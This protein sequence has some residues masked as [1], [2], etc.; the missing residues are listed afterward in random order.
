M[1]VMPTHAIIV[2]EDVGRIYVDTADGVNAADENPST[3]RRRSDVLQWPKE[4]LS[5]DSPAG[6]RLAASAELRDLTNRIFMSA[7]QDAELVP[8]TDGRVGS[9]A[10][11]LRVQ[12]ALLPSAVEAHAARAGGMAPA[13]SA[14]QGASLALA[15]NWLT[16]CC[17]R[18]K[19]VGE[20]Q[21]EVR[22]VA[23]ACC[24]RFQLTR[25]D[26]P[27]FLEHTLLEHGVLWKKR[28]LGDVYQ[29]ISY[30]FGENGAAEV[31]RRERGEEGGEGVMHSAVKIAEGDALSPSGG[32]LEAVYAFLRFLEA[33]ESDRCVR[34]DPAARAAA[35][36]FSPK[37]DAARAVL[38]EALVDLWVKTAQQPQLGGKINAN[39]WL[40]NS[41]DEKLCRAMEGAKA[42]L[43]RWADGKGGGGGGG[44]G[45]SLSAERQLSTVFVALWVLGGPATAIGT[46]DHVLSAES[47]SNM[48][49]GRRRML[50]LQRLEAAAVL[51]EQV[52]SLVVVYTQPHLRRDT[53]YLSVLPTM[54]RTL[55]LRLNELRC[56]CACPCRVPL[57]PAA[58]L[59]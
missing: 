55:T 10:P 27:A 17:R 52:S 14:L 50:W 38:R 51:S 59:A 1:G 24:R 43:F 15:L 30:A 25:P 54:R 19:S 11:P 5:S 57:F 49:P 47:F 31:A 44:D 34:A 41:E 46:L 6:K 13:P 18:E 20:E 36:A 48:P 9:W 32:C 58:L 45:V 28:S 37:T 7:L 12:D 21:Q 42:S 33:R 29:E 23:L 53:S 8:S 2:A 26:N 56:E 39:A 40:R 4:S 22:T 3:L 35:A 16:F